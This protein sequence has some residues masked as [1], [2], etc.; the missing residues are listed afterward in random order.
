MALITK[1]V[2]TRYIGF[3]VNGTKNA[4]TG[5]PRFTVWRV[6]IDGAYY[7]LRFAGNPRFNEG[8]EVN[9]E[10][11]SFNYCN[12]QGQILADQSNPTTGG[13]STGDDGSGG[14]TGGDGSQGSNNDDLP[15][16]DDTSNYPRDDSPLQ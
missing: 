6:L 10:A 4:G 16:A 5:R 3:R 12:A 15:D 9:I 2:H 13:G 7:Y 8:T 14:N 1:L 11:M